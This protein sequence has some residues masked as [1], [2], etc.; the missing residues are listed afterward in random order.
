MTNLFV[1]G[2]RDKPALKE[3]VTPHRI[4]L[5]T[6]IREYCAVKQ[7][8]IE[9]KSQVMT[10]DEMDMWEYTEKEKRDFMITTLELLQCPDMELKSLMNKVQ[11]I[12]KPK[13]LEYFIHRLI[14]FQ[15]EGIG[16]LMDYFQT[17]QENLFTESEPLV[18]KSSVLGLFLRRMI[19]MF[20]KLSFSQVGALYKAYL[21]YYEG[22]R[23]DSHQA[24]LSISLNEADTELDISMDLEDEESQHEDKDIDRSPGVMS[25][26]TFSQRQAEYFIS[27]QAMLLQHNESEAL[28]AGD[29][30][31]KIRE[32]LKSNSDLTEA[33]FLSY[34]NNLRVNEYCGAINSLYHYFDRHQ[35]TNPNAGSKVKEEDY[36]RSFRYAALNLAALHYRFGHRN[37][38]MAA[39]HEA[40]RMAQETNDNICLMHAMGWL[41]ILGE[42]GTTNSAERPG[43]RGVSE[44]NLHYL[45]SLGVQFFAKH[46]AI[47]KAKP[48]SIF[49]YLMKSDILNCQHSQVDLMAI[50][51]AQ[52][53]ALWHLYG[54]REMAS[55]CSQLL[56][57]LN[58]M[59]AGI[60]HNGEAGCLVLCNL[61][62]H[63]A[64]Q[65]QYTE[66][67]HILQCCKQRFPQKSQ[68]AS[69]WMECEQTILFDRAM[70]HGKYKEA[71][72]IVLTMTALNQQE[73]SY[74]K[75]L[76]MK[77]NGETTKAFDLLTSLK[78]N[79]NSQ[80]ESCHP[81]Y[82]VR[83]LLAIGELH[84][85][86]EQPSLA[87]DSFLAALTICNE[88]YFTYLAAMV[89]VYIAYVQLQLGMAQH[90][91]ELIESVMV[92][93]LAQGSLLD[94]SRTNRLYAK[95][96][97]AA[98]EGKNI[99]KKK[100][101]LLTAVNMLNGVLS[102]YEVLEAHFRAKETLHLQ[103][104]LYNEL[105]YF[106][107]RNQCA[108]KF[109]K[110]D[111]QCPTVSSLDL[112]VV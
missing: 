83:V 85:Q 9:L 70:H 7:K 107:E 8:A 103:A 92:T 75:A 43:S 67:Q 45:V 77:A 27:Q 74:R 5:V 95:C 88:H 23:P 17:L 44:T 50:S 71:E 21:R 3:H 39:L 32:L 64:S 4:A 55:L 47:S 66:S 94:R 62:T 65:G 54:N 81:E 30:Q 56:L 13:M 25:D 42:P 111:Q 41:H 93:I 102:G 36:G 96:L 101:A 2:Y 46:N 90:G 10:S 22:W 98:A 109:K 1:L 97:V 86:T 57:N 108:L 37:E 18:N 91:V 15:E 16:A 24:R 51:Y 82:T 12:S 52:K 72:Q 34:L 89:T 40:I 63:F 105:G 19:L 76:L 80:K 61:A 69:V 79:S 11:E 6:L 84:C 29:L 14:H 78:E 31:Q 73:A 60:Y 49:D 38:A 87:L 100:S 106:T 58:T 110:L 48:S 99:E 112:S 28:S 59:E 35:L 26:G 104:C 33:H 53:T 20:D 68:H